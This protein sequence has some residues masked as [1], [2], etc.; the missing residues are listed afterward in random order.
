MLLQ[1]LDRSAPGLQHYDAVLAFTGRQYRLAGDGLAVGV[2]LGM[3]DSRTGRLP[4]GLVDA[5][6]AY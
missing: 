3:L 4:I 2:V 6:N 1:P 5:Q